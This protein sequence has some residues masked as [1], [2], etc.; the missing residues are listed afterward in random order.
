MGS[1][2][3]K[4]VDCMTDSQSDNTDDDEDVINGLQDDLEEYYDF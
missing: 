1:S 3:Q 2:V 4:C